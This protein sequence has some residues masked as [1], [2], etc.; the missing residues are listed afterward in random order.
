[1]SEVV[2]GRNPV[3]EALRANRAINKILVAKGSSQRDLKEII[4]LAQ[5]RGIP[6]QWVPRQKLESLAQ[7]KGHQGVV[8]LASPVPFVE[9]SDIL[10]RAQEKGQ[11]PFIIILDHLEDPHNLGAILRT[12]EAV[13]VHGVVIP[14]RRSVTVTSTV[15]K[16]SAGAVEY[17]PIARVTNLRQAMDELKAQGLWIMG[18]DIQGHKSFYEVD[19]KGPLALVIGSE[20]QGLGR[21]VKENCDLLIKI[22]MVGHLNSLNASVA[23]SIIMY[24]AF[25][26]RL[27]G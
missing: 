21:L 27:G 16:T 3:W 12:A 23:A 6:V 24:E 11:D 18:A 9:L 2:E 26:Q 25:K 14:K 17:V 5:E 22:P 1:M 7:T 4:T 20:G 15:T 8:A 13:G 10:L 19:F